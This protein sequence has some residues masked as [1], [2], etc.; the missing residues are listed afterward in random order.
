MIPLAILYATHPGTGQPSDHDPLNV[1]RSVVLWP[2]SVQPVLGVA[3]T[4]TYEM[5]FYVLFGC[6]IVAGRWAMWLLPAW[7]LAI[8]VAQL[9]A[10]LAFPIGFILSPYN[11]E[12]L[13]G[14]AC[15]LLLHDRP[16]VPSPWQVPIGALAF[17][18]A[19]FMP[20]VQDPPI[21]GRL[22]FGA[23]SVV[24][25]TGMVGAQARGRISLPQPLLLLGAASYAIYLIHPVAISFLCQLVIRLGGRHLSADVAVIALSLLA[26]G[27]GLIF[28]L[29]VEK[30]AMAL[31][32]WCLDYRPFRGPDIPAPREN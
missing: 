4:L 31:V 1:L 11:L 21:V 2:S 30:R 9:W 27:V 10:P 15:A 12:F 20:H 29:L 25:L 26:I 7:A 16:A 32:A 3:W 17:G 18:V 8:L 13:A 14:I 23:C 6:L 5:F 19:L 24:I 22:V 28:H